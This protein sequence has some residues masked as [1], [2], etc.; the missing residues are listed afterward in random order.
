MC[1]SRPLLWSGVSAD[2]DSYSA[3]LVEQSRKS[4]T[5]MEQGD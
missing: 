1:S 3:R 5:V 2:N 4:K